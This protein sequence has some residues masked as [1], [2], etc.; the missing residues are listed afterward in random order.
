[1]ENVTFL[2]LIAK[3][4][5]DG[6]ERTATCNYDGVENVA[7]L[8]LVRREEARLRHEDFI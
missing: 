2:R 7:N 3:I 6:V 8:F 1:L 4:H 5:P